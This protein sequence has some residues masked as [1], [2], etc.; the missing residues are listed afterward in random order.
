M[1]LS[2]EAKRQVHNK[3]TNGEFCNTE[4]GEDKMSQ[5]LFIKNHLQFKERVKKGMTFRRIWYHE[6]PQPLERLITEVQTNGFWVKEQG[7]VDL[8]WVDYMTSRDW[9][10]KDGK[11]YIIFNHDLD[12]KR[13]SKELNAQDYSRYL[14]RLSEY[15]KELEVADF[16]KINGYKILGIYEIVS[17]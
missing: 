11:V 7:S 6:D 3:N 10:F 8:M 12:K 9:A 17:Q 16:P 5:T 15:E 4:I 13:K 1:I 14:K 2:S